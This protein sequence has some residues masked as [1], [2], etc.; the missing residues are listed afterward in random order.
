MAKVSRVLAKALVKMS[1]GM[2]AKVPVGMSVA[3]SAK[4]PTF[5][6]RIEI[7]GRAR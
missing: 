2:S 4:A 7:F 1:V 6:R 3:A 5:G